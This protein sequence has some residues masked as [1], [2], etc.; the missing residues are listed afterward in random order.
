M[1]S[2][3]GIL[4][5]I[6]TLCQFLL[7]P[8]TYLFSRDT[9]TTGHNR[10]IVPG[11][12]VVKL[13]PPTG[14]LERSSLMGTLVS[15]YG[16]EQVEQLFPYQKYQSSA[17]REVHDLSRIYRLTVP[18][19]SDVEK[20]CAELN[21][22]SD[23]EYAEPV[24]LHQTEEIPNDTYY[25]YQQHLP[26]IAAEQAWDVAKGD[27]SIVIAIIDT[28]V[29]WDHPDL[30]ENVWINHGE[31]L[32]GTDTDDNGY[33]DDIRGWDWV[34]GATDPS[35]GEDGDVEDN[36][37]MDFDGHGTHVAGIAGA[38]TDN[39]A[40]VASVSWNCAIMPL[41]VGWA[42]PSSSVGAFVRSDW[43]AQAF[44]YA[45][46]NGAQVANY[47][48]GNSQIILEGARYAFD[49]GVVIVTSA[50]NGND[51]IGDPL[52]LA[53][54]GL[55]VAAVNDV[56]EKASYSTYGEWVSVSA[57]GGDV[58]SGGRRDIFSTV[59]DN[60]YA[61]YEGTSMASPVVAG[62]AGLVKA[63]HPDW[64]NADVVFQIINTADNIDHLNPQYAGKLGSGRINAYR[65]VTEP[66]FEPDP[67]IILTSTTIDDAVGGNN[68]GVTN[69]GE[70]LSLIVE[71]MN[72]MGNA[73]NVMIN[74]IL[75][76]PSIEIIDGTSSIGLI[77]GLR[78]L[79]NNRTDNASDPLVLQ[80]D[81]LALPHRVQGTIQLT[82]DNY[83]ETYDL[84]FAI[85][86]SVLLVD[87]EELDGEQYYI[88]VLDS[89]GISFD[90]WDRNL[91]NTP[92]NL[93]SYS[94]VIWFCEW[95][96]PSLNDSDRNVIQ[97]Y[98]D[99]GG[100]LFLSGQDIGW[101]L[102]DST[103]TTFIASG[104]LS[105][106][107]YEDYLHAQY[108]LDTSDYSLLNGVQGDPIG[109][110]LSF[111][112]YQPGRDPENQYPDEINPIDGSQSIFN[113][114]NGNSGAVRY[115]GD[116]RTVFFGFGG[117]EA[118][119]EP[120]VRFTVMGR[121]LDWLNGLQISHQP[122]KDT[123]NFEGDYDIQVSVQSVVQP[124][125]KVELYWDIDSDLP[126]NEKITMNHTGDGVYEGSIPAQPLGTEIRYT[127]LVQTASG[128]YAP[129]IIN[130]FNVEE[131]VTPPTFDT[132][133]EIA[134]SMSKTGP[135]QLSALI[136]DNADL[137]VDTNSVTFYYS[138]EGVEDSLQMVKGS[139]DDQYEVTFTGNYS[140]GD[141]L[142]YYLSA[143]DNAVHPNKGI[144]STYQLII[145]YEGFE[146]GLG[147]WDADSLTWGLEQGNSHSGGYHVS[148]S[149]GCN[150]LPGTNAALTLLSPL[151]ISS[152]DS[153][154]LSFWTRY[155]LQPGNRG[156][157]YVE[158]S[159]DNGQNWNQVGSTIVGIATGWKQIQVSLTDYAGLDEVLLRFRLWSDSTASSNY[160]G[161]L[162]DDIQIVEVVQ[163][164]IP[165]IAAED[166]VPDQFY[167]SQNFPNPFN[168]ETNIRYQLKVRGPVAITIHNALG[169]RVK[170]VVN[171][172]QPAGRYTVIWNG[173]SDSGAMVGSGIYFLRMETPGFVQ[174]RKMVFLK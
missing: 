173:E 17:E 9:N 147:Q 149:P 68:D 94:T 154:D 164:G 174:T 67:H 150:Y 60:R 21:T 98:L 113:Y 47:S 104:G 43:A 37:P 158:V 90:Y 76:D 24:Y 160:D 28:G 46:D 156:N 35:T 10:F 97:N 171:E 157:G 108:I 75:D 27:T 166:A 91:N 64:S 71:L 159:T 12:V 57:P 69:P 14:N 152:A 8:L 66:F 95:T 107:F 61:W 102:C 122:L 72:N 77:T 133:H 22:R 155:R 103:G 86:P 137:G 45:A 138:S 88:S 50:G 140:Y 172:V 153:V 51:E 111:S 13:K 119:V 93:S 131:D 65:A 169:Q 79:D 62:L 141:T 15:Q 127:I 148:D 6:V 19:S 96:F 36:D 101:D 55:S 126:F 145:G 92:S 109:H 106:D 121:V 3:L 56:D 167:L 120:D 80:I 83:Y 132:V 39:G 33:V 116:Y 42:S 84:H 25:N 168:P 11:L 4:L 105:K 87:D 81:A 143:R 129:L 139:T 151:D 49:V 82:A 161:W 2:R 114:P 34:D 118:I 163:T 70:R 100:H 73:S 135:Y 146:N 23:M 162:I 112:V 26:Q 41:R 142:D 38:V 74:L 7:V 48:A 29:D 125:D 136:T 32:D 59:F 44:R 123:Y 115:G 134:N 144:S 128:Y 1:K 170:T 130:S 53:S 63:Q 18:Q 89:L 40:G 5:W 30:A 31:M 85:S 110:G 16:V 124:V 117:Y 165:E 58:G 20:I 54:Y 78:D 52:S 99:G